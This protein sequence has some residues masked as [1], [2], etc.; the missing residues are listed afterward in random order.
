MKRA[1]R[2]ENERV[3]RA[4][5]KAWSGAAESRENEGGT[6]DPDKRCECRGKY[7]RGNPP[8]RHG[9]SLL[10]RPR[11]AVSPSFPSLRPRR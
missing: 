9:E 4:E 6:K 2:G 3:Q 10:I 7:R 11:Y 1:E 8:Q 5:L